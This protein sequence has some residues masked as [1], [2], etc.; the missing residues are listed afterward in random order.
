MYYK[1]T[2]EKTSQATKRDGELQ[3]KGTKNH[4]K[5]FIRK[6]ANQERTSQHLQVLTEKKKKKLPSVYAV[7]TANSFQQ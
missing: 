7:S 4:S 2:M 3:T 1:L 5:L 6:L